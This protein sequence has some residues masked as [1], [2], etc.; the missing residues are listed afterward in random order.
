MS[1]HASATQRTAR[2]L[3]ASARSGSAS[4]ASTAVHAAQWTTTS[5]R[6]VGDRRI[7]ARR[8][9]T[10]SSAWVRPM[11]S[12]PAALGRR[13]DVVTE[14]AT[15]AGDES[16]HV[17]AVP[18]ATGARSRSGSH[19]CAVRR[20]PVDRR[21]DAAVPVDLR[22][23]SRARRGSSTSR[24]RSGDRDR[25]GQGRSSSTT[26]A[27]RGARGSCRRSARCCARR[28][29]RRGR[30]PRPTSSRIT[31]IARQWSTSVDP[32]A[33]GSPS[34]RTAAAARRRAPAW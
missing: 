32:L 10:S 7:T 28:R 22:C 26:P 9:V 34:R 33:D 19:H 4:H 21:G 14:L 8:S 16:L 1:S 12:S 3:T 27:C 24:G 15:G 5:G 6:H 20:V 25:D 13:H 23:S 11:T 30:S 17:Q 2:P 29:C 18:S 31:S